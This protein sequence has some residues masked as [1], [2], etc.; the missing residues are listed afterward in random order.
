[1]FVVCPATS[2]WHNLVASIAKDFKDQDLTF[3]I[4][5][6]E[7]FPTDIKVLGMDDWGEDIIVGIFAPDNVRYPMKEELYADSLR[8]FVSEFLAGSLEPYLRSEPVP[9][10]SKTA[11]VETVVGS[12]FQRFMN[13]PDRASL[14]KLCMPDARDCEDAEKHFEQVVIRYEGSQ[15]VV[16]GEMNMA[17]ND[18]PIGTKL[19]EAELPAYL[20]SAAGSQSIAQ[21]SPKPT[22][23]ND[24]LFFLKYRNSLRPTV[25]DREL[26]RRAEK[27]KKEQKKRKEKAKKAKQE[28]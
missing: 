3:A 14:I 16:F 27:K 15:E 19:E 7:D 26:D 28:L 12:T 5:N 13:N 1:M 22:D 23:E 2:Y 17:L 18:I 11:L 4:A 25:S 8:E 10:R 20:F 9:K 21:V 24:I 6:E